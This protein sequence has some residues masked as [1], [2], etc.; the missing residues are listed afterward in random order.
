MIFSPH[1]DDD[2]ITMSAAILKL[3]QIGADIEIVYLTTGENAVRINFQGT[4]K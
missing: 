2:V 4:K 3:V 1:P